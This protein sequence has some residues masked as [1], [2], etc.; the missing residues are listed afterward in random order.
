VPVKV[1]N[2]RTNREARRVQQEVADL[3]KRN[4][5]PIRVRA[6]VTIDGQEVDVDTLSPEMR[7]EVAT[8]LKLKYLN[9][10][11]RGTAVFSVKEA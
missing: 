1:P 2:H 10:L 6:F 11:F 4:N 3:A 8:Q 7:Q 5:E 9:A